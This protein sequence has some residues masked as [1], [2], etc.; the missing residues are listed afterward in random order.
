LGTG[1]LN[2]GPQVC[3][4]SALP[5]EPFLQLSFEFLPCASRSQWESCVAMVLCQLTV[6]CLVHMIITTF[7][8]PRPAREMEMTC[9]NVNLTVLWQ[10]SLENTHL[11]PIMLSSLDLASTFL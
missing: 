4:A 9:Q 8:G 5:T 10:T 2:S 6:V 3:V 11:H 7:Q 1:D